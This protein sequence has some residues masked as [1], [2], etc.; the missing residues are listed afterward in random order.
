MATGTL[1]KTDTAVII[2]YC[3][4]GQIRI[5]AAELEFVLGCNPV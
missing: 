4:V 2:K 3:R 5:L 1:S